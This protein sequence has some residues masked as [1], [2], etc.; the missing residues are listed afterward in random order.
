VQAALQA[1]IKRLGSQVSVAQELGVSPA[2]VNH[3]M[4]DRYAGDVAGMADRIRGQFM[5]QMVACPVMGELGL[6][7]CLDNQSRPLAFTNPT[8]VALYTACKTCPNRKES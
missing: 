1:A 4:R 2:V 3:L 8:R 6:R 5:K 7:H